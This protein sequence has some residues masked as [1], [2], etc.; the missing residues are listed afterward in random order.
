MKAI[1][2]VYSPGSCYRLQ[3]HVACSKMLG[4][5]AAER[6][7]GYRLVISFRLALKPRTPLTQE[8]IILNA[9]ENTSLPHKIHKKS[10][11]CHEEKRK[12]GSSDQN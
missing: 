8:D 11:R 6:R 10:T 4:L 12:K 2:I 5:Q 1:N 7:E 3:Y 9:M